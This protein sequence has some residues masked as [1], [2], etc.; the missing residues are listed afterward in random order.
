MLAAPWTLVSVA[1]ASARSVVHLHTGVSVAAD[2]LHVLHAA[3]LK[4]RL[5]CSSCCVDDLQVFAIEADRIR[6][7]HPDL[8][9][10]GAPHAKGACAFLDDRGACRIYDERPYVCRTQGLPL[11]WL[12]ENDD[13]STVELRDI[14]PLNDADPALDPLEALPAETCW[15]IGPI[16]EELAKMQLAIDAK[17][18]RVALRDLFTNHLANDGTKQKVS[19]S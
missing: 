6:A 5:G 4:C 17:A 14:C 2:A 9:A 19:E 10:I 3:R 12:E 7:C 16:E 1:L 15:T 11:R 8:L 18:V 13:D